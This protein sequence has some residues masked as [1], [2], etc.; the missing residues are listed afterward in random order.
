LLIPLLVLVRY[1]W[2]YTWDD[3]AIA[4]GFSKG[5][6]Y[7]HEFNPTELS[8]VVEG[9]SNFLWVVLW[10]PLFSLG[11]SDSTVFHVMRATALVINIGN[12]FLVTV[13]L[14]RRLKS[15]CLIWLGSAVFLFSSITIVESLDGME[16]PFELFLIL[17][18]WYLYDSARHGWFAIVSSLLIL[19]RLEAAFT[20]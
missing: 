15:P 17:T 10:A 4:L 2:F 20:S 9:F 13:I 14:N 1:G 3:S 5:L 18:S 16:G 6:A 11:L 7:F 19:V 8:E 12:S